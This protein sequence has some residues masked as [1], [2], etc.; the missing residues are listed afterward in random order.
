MEIK[1]R[2]KKRYDLVI[3]LVVVIV[4]VAGI[5]TYIAYLEHNKASQ[6]KV[7]SGQITDFSPSLP[8]LLVVTINNPSKLANPYN[9]TMTLDLSDGQSVALGY[10]SL[11]EW[12]YHNFVAIVNIQSDSVTDFIISTGTEIDIGNTANSNYNFNG[13]TVILTYTGYAGAITYN[14]G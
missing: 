14:I 10:F 3:V 1:Q 2:P 8:S 5:S 7:L 6:G 4:I 9:V 12:R 11:N 13:T